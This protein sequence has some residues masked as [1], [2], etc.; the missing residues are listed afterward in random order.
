VMLLIGT[1]LGC[2]LAFSTLRMNFVQQVS[3]FAGLA[4]IFVVACGWRH[5]L[6]YFPVVS[7]WQRR[8]AIGLCWAMALG[9]GF[10]ASF[11]HAVTHSIEQA[12]SGATNNLILWIIWGGVPMALCI[13]SALALSM[14][15]EAR[16]HWGMN[17]GHNFNRTGHH[18]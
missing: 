14:D 1:V 13:C 18:V 15:R 17:T 5:A 7:V 4:L 3:A 8:W 16:Q 10:L 6:A 9:F 2:E 11:C 12:P